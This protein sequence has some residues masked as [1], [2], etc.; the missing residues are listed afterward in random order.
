[1]AGPTVNTHTSG[2]F[3][4]SSVTTGALNVPNGDAVYVIIFQNVLSTVTGVTDSTGLNTYTLKKSFGG[5]VGLVLVYVADNVTGN[6]AL[7]VTI[8]LNASTLTS[9]VV[10]DIIGAANPSFDKAGTGASG[11]YTSGATESDSLSP[12]SG[13]DLLL[14]CMA[15]TASNTSGTPSATFQT[16]AGESLVDQHSQG[17]A[18]PHTCVAGGVYSAPASGTGS[19]TLNGSAS[20]ATSIARSYAAIAIAILPNVA[21]VTGAG[22]IGEASTLLLS[23]LV[24]G[25]GHIGEAHGLVVSEK[26]SGA[27]HVG[28]AAGLVVSE[29]SAGAD[30]IAE[31]SS[32]MVSQGYQGTGHI[33]E[34]SALRL[35]QR[36]SGAEHIGE[37]AALVVSEVLTGSGHIGESSGLVVNERSTGAGQVGE[38]STLVLS[39]RPKGA[40][41]IQQR[42]IL[43]IAQSPQGA[44]TIGERA[45][46]FVPTPGELPAGGHESSLFGYGVGELYGYRPVIRST[47]AVRQLR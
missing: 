27:G 2:G 11:S 46:L 12:T 25:A 31:S 1:M 37:S 3:L 45:S 7:T 24:A 20:V 14:L 8:N 15:V 17:N 9:Y 28:E 5:S 4:A 42:A 18:T 26:S 32:L 41:G 35:S 38:A 47:T 40:E 6:A 44:G 10:L 39:E 29:V 34:S 30:H 22:H 21:T 43:S 23:Q 13:S 19:Q 33:A 16:Q 36:F